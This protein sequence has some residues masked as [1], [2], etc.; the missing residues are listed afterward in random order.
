MADPDS[1]GDF[2]EIPRR[3]QGDLVCSYVDVEWPEHMHLIPLQ[4][5]EFAVTGTS[6]RAARDDRREWP[7]VVLFW[8]N[9]PARQPH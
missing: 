6:F 2:R 9:P 4:G 5:C 1:R 3:F 7:I 8:I